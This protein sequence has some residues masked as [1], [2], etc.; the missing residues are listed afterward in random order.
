MNIKKILR[1]IY[2]SLI[3]KQ[4]IWSLVGEDNINKNLFRILYVGK[5][6]NKNYIAH[7]AFNK[8][9]EEKY[10]GP[11]WKGMQKILTFLAR[12][13]NCSLLVKEENYFNKKYHNQ[14]NFCI[15]QWLD[16]KVDVPII[17]KNKS[18]K[19]EVRKILKNKLDYNVTTEISLLDYF[20]NNMYLPY[21][22][23][24]FKNKAIIT[25]YKLIRKEMAAG[26]CKLLLI[27]KNN[28][29]IAGGLMRFESII[30]KV[31]CLGI[32]NTEKSYF[33]DG[34]LSAI[35]YFSSIYLRNC[36]Y[37]TMRLGY[38]RTFFSDGVFNYKKK[39]GIEVVEK[40]RKQDKNAF[41]IQTLKHDNYSKSFFL[42]NYFVLHENGKLK[43][44][45]FF[46]NDKILS[47][48]YIK[49]LTKTFLISG[50]DKLVIYQYKHI[51]KKPVVVACISS[52]C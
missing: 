50:I 27:K 13:K 18:A 42:N 43:S 44:A 4:K 38:S 2:S 34:A 21:I 40:E 31:W 7:L 3:P 22:E 25:S 29:F 14:D 15:P 1:I 26:R 35:Y 33:K 17:P 8:L 37:D 30:P 36:G 19:N 52:R 28:E 5:E 9:D 12:I 48:N 46:D 49:K 41:I 20:Y 16:S 10:L 24:R 39:W 45:I 11:A 32:T 23:E 47:V 6:V 51:N